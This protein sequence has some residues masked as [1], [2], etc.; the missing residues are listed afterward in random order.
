M[1]LQ[2]MEDFSEDSL[3]IPFSGSELEE[4]N[5]SLTCVDKF[6]KDSANSSLSS[7]VS[8]SSRVLQILYLLFLLTS[9]TILNSLVVYLVSRSKK[10][11]TRAFAVAVQIAL[12]NL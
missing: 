2:A 11:R 9:G 8:I 5:D 10:L 1:T 12:A 4:D 3:I 6:L 7:S